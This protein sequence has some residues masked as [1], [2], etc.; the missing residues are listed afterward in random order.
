MADIV[1][2][3]R[4]DMRPF[5]SSAPF[6]VADAI[7]FSQ[8]VY[9]NMPSFV[10]RLETQHTPQTPQSKPIALSQLLRRENYAGMV[11]TMNFA[12]RVTELI[13]VCGESPRYRD[14]KVGAIVEPQGP[15]AT[16]RFAAMTFLLPSPY[17]LAVVA[18]RGTDNTLAGWYED[19]RLLFLTPPL[20]SQAR[21][22]NYLATVAGSPLYRDMPIA[23]TGHS[24]GGNLAEYAAASAA[25]TVKQRISSIWSQ[26]SPGFT[27][28]FIASPQF[29][30]I[31]TRLH[32]TVPTDSLVGMLFDSGV[33]EKVVTSSAHGI[34]QHFMSTWQ[35]APTTQTTATTPATSTKPDEQLTN[36]GDE[37]PLQLKTVAS[38]SRSSAFLGTVIDKWR[39][40]VD[41][42][43]RRQLIDN[44]FSVLRAT[45]YDNFGDMVANWTTSV[46]KA[47]SA[48]HALTPE[49]Q[50]VIR[51]V[52]SALMNVLLTTP[53]IAKPEKTGKADKTDKTEKTDKPDKS[54]QAD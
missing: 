3:V 48:Y 20:P 23:L 22:A 11:G 27:D 13:R 29:Q 39:R 36:Q 37:P 32:R 10:P 5:S 4:A 34:M 1:D 25:D 42:Q 49:D 41:T 31:H 19:F 6:C 15:H 8:L 30:S 14:V 38:V 40:S 12:D 54:D 44:L 7:V 45:G 35:F 17:P 33:E 9:L 50:H 46:L 18:F 2:A 51:E 21:A 43:K 28:D 52:L 24:W 16:D 53:D 47:N 26:D